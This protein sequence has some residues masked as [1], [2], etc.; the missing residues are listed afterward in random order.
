MKKRPYRL[1]V[2]HLEA[3]EL[4]DVSLPRT[5][6]GHGFPLPPGQGAAA[7]GQALLAPAPGTAGLQAD[8]PPNLPGHEVDAIFGNAEE[9]TKLCGDS[10]S[11][12]DQGQDAAA[13]GLLFMQNYARKAIQNEELK[14]GPLPDHEDQVHQIFVTWRE[15]V[16]DDQVA[17]ANL[18]LKESPERQILRQSVRR[19]IDLVRYQSNKQRR[20]RPV[21]D[22]AARPSPAGQEWQDLRV[23]LESGVGNL[24]AQEKQI[25]ELRRQGQTF[26]EIGAELGLPKQRV[27]EKF[28]AVISRLQEIYSRP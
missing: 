3:R 20:M 11:G 19:E 28:T 1:E 13:R 9:V 2:E 17:L 10:W 16:G 21:E 25:L 15:Q 18:L 26:D 24:S 27:S 8:A 14:Y 22:Q 7:Q 4:L 6:A 12:S 23:D 5:A